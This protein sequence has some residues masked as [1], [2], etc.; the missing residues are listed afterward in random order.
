MEMDSGADLLVDEGAFEFAW[1]FAA[2]CGDWLRAAGA[3]K[4]RQVA[5]NGIKKWHRRI[6]EVFYRE[7][8]RAQGFPGR[9]VFVQRKEMVPEVVAA[10]MRADPSPMRA[11]SSCL[12]VVE[13]SIITGI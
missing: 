10:S 8:F 11:R 9:G 13:P 12:E 5:A 4:I 2:G 7:F 1:G 6:V 3:A